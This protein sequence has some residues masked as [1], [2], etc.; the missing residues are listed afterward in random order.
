MLQ[1]VPQQVVLAHE[2][3]PR[4][5]ARSQLSTLKHD[6]HSRRADGSLHME[7]RMVF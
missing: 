5:D 2:V 4:D 7:A 6:R 3:R 1:F